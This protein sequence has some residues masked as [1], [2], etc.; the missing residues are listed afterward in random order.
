M[1]IGVVDVPADLAADLEA[2][3]PREHDVEQDEV[4]A[5]GAPALEAVDA[6]GG[7][8]DL[9]PAAPQAEGGHLA[10][11]RVVLDE[12]DPAAAADPDVHHGVR[13]PVVTAGRSAGL[14]GR[15]PPPRTARAATASQCRNEAVERFAI[16]ADPVIALAAQLV[17]TERALEAARLIT[18]F[19]HG[20]VSMELTGAFRLGGD[21]DRAY[22]YGVSVLVE[23][24][25]REG[26]SGRPSSG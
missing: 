10:D 2:V 7:G 15:I 9:N 17:G 23:A 14:G 6:V 25:V 8:R 20:F 12:Q 21:V 11:R 5:V 1:T 19:A 3:E 16:A 22:D 13:P 4:G 18:A 26:S 24:L